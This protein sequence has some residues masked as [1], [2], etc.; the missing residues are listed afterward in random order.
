MPLKFV[1]GVYFNVPS[2]LITTAPFTALAVVTVSGSPSG[3]LSL[4]S[5]LMLAIGV[6][7]VVEAVLSV[8]TGAGFVTVQL[9]ACVA[10]NPPASRAVTTMA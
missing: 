10:V 9:N 3:S 7:S 1:F 4:P 5:T 6:S 8:A 2:G